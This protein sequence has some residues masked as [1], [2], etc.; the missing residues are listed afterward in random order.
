MKNAYAKNKKGA[1]SFY[2]VAF[3]TL[4]LVILASSF[5]AAVIVQIARSSNDDLAQSA[6][7]SAMAGIEDAKVAFANYYNCINSGVIENEA[8]A[9]LRDDLPE[10]TCEDIVYWVNHPNENSDKY[11]SCDM[12]AHILGRIGKTESGEVPI[13]E[14]VVNRENEDVDNGMDQAYTCVKIETRLDDYRAT[15]TS[16]NPYKIVKVNF[17]HADASKI[18]KVRI[19]W[20]QIDN[21]T[22]LTFNNATSNGATFQPLLSKEA[23]VP[24]TLAVTLLQ[25]SFDGNIQEMMNKIMIGNESTDRSTMYFVPTNSRGTAMTNNLTATETTTF[26]GLYDG[27]DN[28]IGKS[29]IASMNDHAKDYPYMVYCDTSKEYACSVTLE[30]PTPIDGS[31]NRDEKTFMFIVQMPYEKPDTDFAIEYICGDASDNCHGDSTITE[32]SAIAQI[33]NAQILIDSTGRANDLFRRVETRLEPADSVFEYPYYAVQV[34]SLW[35]DLTVTSEYGDYTNYYVDVD[36][37]K[38]PEPDCPANT[39]CYRP[40]GADGGIDTME[41]QSVRSNSSVTLTA[42]NYSREGYGFAGWNTESNGS[43]TNYGPN[44][45]INTG[46]LS[47]SGLILYARWVEPTGNLQNW[48]G[49]GAMSTGTVTALKDTRDNQVYA[50]AKLGDGKCWMIENLRLNPQSANINA[51]NTNNPTS[52]FLS[53][54]TQ[55]G[56]E[57]SWPSKCSGANATTATEAACPKEYQFNNDNINRSLP[58]SDTAGGSGGASWYSYGVMYNYHVAS[59]GNNLSLGSSGGTLSGD[60]CPAGWKLPSSNITGGDADILNRAVNGGSRNTSAGL[61]TYPNNFIYSGFYYLNRANTSSWRGT[62]ASL[63]G[64]GQHGVS[65]YSSILNADTIDFDAR[66][67]TVTGWASAIGVGQAIRCIVKTSTTP[68]PTPDEPPVTTNKCTN[69]ATCMQ[70]TNNCSGTLTDA[71]DGKQYRVAT[72]AG[73]CYMVQNLRFTG[74]VSNDGLSNYSGESYNV[75]AQDLASGNGNTMYISRCHS[76]SDTVW[77]NYV[78]ASAGTITG[79]K[80]TTNDATEDIC[81]AGWRLPSVSEYSKITSYVSLFS[82]VYG[83]LYVSGEPDYTYCGY[84]WTSTAANPYTDIYGRYRLRYVSGRLETSEGYYSLHHGLYVRC[85]KK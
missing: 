19:S 85:T 80:N 36:P 70:T 34:G 59:A 27:N 83:G 28:I 62:Y 79:Q 52:A 6:Y 17:T 76:G 54:R 78:A 81:P 44:Q 1:A 3:S 72:I 9:K 8:N 25:S 69:E 46:D 60:L 13:R 55:H 73:R 7:D 42:S 29:L 67:V 38:E 4:I 84:W 47:A 51:S 66:S 31:K 63:W 24:A 45:T 40:N 57:E 53:E 23:S 21:E 41:N 14:S 5:A 71:R 61:R 11:K 58:A 64:D 26:R 68:T 37:L 77:Y 39:I 32:N 22:N 74:T 75:C 48:N 16:M 2:V 35:K 30:L 50:V 12:V 18:K 49:C 56:S 15:L 43:G 20:Q 82:P 65:G 10:I 33:G